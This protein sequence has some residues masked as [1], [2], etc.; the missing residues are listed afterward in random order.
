MPT[1]LD[2]YSELVGR[3]KQMA[4]GSYLNRRLTRQK[5]RD[6]WLAE[7]RVRWT[8]P[9]CGERFHYYSKKCA[10]CSQPVKICRADL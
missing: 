6:K 3:F 10:R 4:Y 2:A 7:Q 5:G 9:N 1:R 8:C